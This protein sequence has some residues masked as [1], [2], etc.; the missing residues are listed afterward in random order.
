[1]GPERLTSSAW[2]CQFI[3]SSPPEL[4]GFCA[5]GPSHDSQEPS[6]GAW[7]VYHLHVAPNL[8]GQG[9]GDQL[10]AAAVERGAGAG[11]RALT[12]WVIALNAANR[13]FYARQG[14]RTDGAEQI[15]P[16]GGGPAVAEVRYRLDLPAAS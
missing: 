3:E 13:R 16:L 6:P 9:I 10:F 4:A 11:Y 2:R 7:E 15:R 8:R 1:M 5:C 14:M 12:L